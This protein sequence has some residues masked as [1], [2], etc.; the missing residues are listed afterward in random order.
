MDSMK[1]AI[2]KLIV[3]SSMFLIKNQSVGQQSKHW[4]PTRK[5]I[6]LTYQTLSSIMCRI[7][8]SSSSITTATLKRQK[9][10]YKNSGKN[11]SLKL[12]KKLTSGTGKVMTPKDFPKIVSNCGIPICTFLR[13]RK[14]AKNLMQ[15]KKINGK[16]LERREI[17]FMKMLRKWSKK[18]WLRSD[19]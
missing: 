19:L 14:K 7:N 2:T 17:K 12:I 16:K 3:R 11:G 15:F 1:K 13:G 5:T 10:H 6:L 4:N 18:S 8:S 9:L